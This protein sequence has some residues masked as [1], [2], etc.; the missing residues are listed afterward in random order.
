MKRSIF[1]LTSPTFLSQDIKLQSPGPFCLCH[2]LRSAGYMKRLQVSLYPSDLD[3]SLW[4]WMETQ[5]SLTTVVTRNPFSEP[6]WGPPLISAPGFMSRMA[7]C[8]KNAFLLSNVD[9]FFSHIIVLTYN[10]EMC[11]ALH[12]STSID[13]SCL[14]DVFGAVFSKY[15]HRSKEYRPGDVNIFWCYNIMLHCIS[16]LPNKNEGCLMAQ[17]FK[18]CL[19]TGVASSGNIQTLDWRRDGVTWGF[20]LFAGRHWCKCLISHIRSCH[21]TQLFQNLRRNC[22]NIWWKCLP[23]SKIHSFCQ[24]TLAG[25]PLP[26]QG[27][28]QDGSHVPVLKGQAVTTKNRPPGKVKQEYW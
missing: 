22:V 25:P 18:L 10:V 2:R 24:A 13:M 7:W 12:E 26:S 19:C 15:S 21:F 5:T 9:L 17:L 16:H 28:G 4:I 3:G 14:C 20:E 11:I 23:F 6:S 27:F 1:L 8:R